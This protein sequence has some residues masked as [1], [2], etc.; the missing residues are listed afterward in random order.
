[1]EVNAETGYLEAT[2]RNW[3]DVGFTAEKKKI[4]IDIALAYVQKNKAF[5]PIN[6][7]CDQLGV[8]V[9]T[10]KKHRL[11]DPKF[12]QDWKEITERLH[13]GLVINLDGK[14]KNKM[15]TLA[16]LSLLRFLETGS[17]DP[18][19]GLNPINSNSPTKSILSRFETCIDAEILPDPPQIEGNKSV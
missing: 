4:F 3:K 14:A 18:N 1:M 10:F 13:N 11:E 12:G 6:E 7:I 9:A 8:S 15:G 16:A 19:K 5:P 17:F 2:E